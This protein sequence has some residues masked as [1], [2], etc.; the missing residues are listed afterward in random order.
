MVDKDGAIFVGKSTKPEY[1]TLALANRHGLVTGATG[2]GKTVSLQ[3]LAEGLSRAGVSVFAADIKGDLSGISQPGEAK[4]AFVSRAKSLGFDYETDQFPV[5]FWDLFGEQGH[6][7][8]AT[9][10]EMGP[11]LLSRLL[12][13][14]DVQEGVLNICFRVAD[15]QGLLVLDLKDLRAMLGYAADHAAELTTQYG[16]VSKQTVGTIQRSLLV[17]E[18]QGGAKFFG[19]PALALKDFIRAD[20]DGRGTV[21]ILAADKLMENPRLYATFL[22]WLLSEL[23][24]ELPEVGDPPKPKLCFFFDEAH[25]LFNDAPK[26][27]L[28]KIEQVV[29]LIRSKG[30]GVYFVTQNP[31]DVPDKVL[32]QLGNRVQHALRAFTPRDQKAVK[33]AAETFRPN[34]KLDT[35]KVIMEL[36]KGEALVSFLEGNGTPSM[37]E[38]CMVRPPSARLGPITAD[39]RKALIAKSPVKGKYDQ[40]VDSESAYEVLQKRLQQ[41]GSTSPPPAGAP[42]PGAPGQ[43]APAA[44][45]LGAILSAIGAALAGIFG[46]SRPR[47][48]R[49]ST[50][51]LIARE[52]ARSVT[53]RVAGQ[54]AA[55]VGKSIGGKA[56]GSVGRAIVRGTMGGILRR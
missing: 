29:R 27:L 52:L 34:P 31:L 55:D 51:Q 46:T 2:T 3:V 47:G 33:A 8:R 23:F 5:M 15:E 40:A 24:E 28:D 50:G 10:S 48:Q 19:E 53:N 14:N 54:I 9:V 42:P 56:G 13:L 36:G 32:A 22:L 38:R 35:T 7:I 1:L 43:E 37:V 18:N 17:L 4:E 6:P 25:L 12:D 20:R 26:A 41:T 39:E 45:G 30:V 21:N 49:L 44:G 16:N 11:L